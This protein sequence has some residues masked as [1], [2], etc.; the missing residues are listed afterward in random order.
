MNALAATNLSGHNLQSPLHVLVLD[1]D[2]FDR[3]RVR[4]WIE[5]NS[6]ADVD[7]TEAADLSVFERCLSQGYFDLVLLDYGL[8]DGTGLDAVSLL[9]GHHAQAASY[10]VMISGREDDS[11]RNLCLREGCDQFMSKSALDAARIGQIIAAVQSRRLPA[12]LPP[13]TPQQSAL[14]YWRVRAER[15]AQTP[16]PF[17]PSGNLE[18]LRNLLGVDLEPVDRPW[19]IVP[20]ALNTFALDDTLS[21][22]LRLFIVDFLSCDEFDF[23]PRTIAPQDQELDLPR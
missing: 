19:N 14:D 5:R 15:R 21:A 8:A 4:R 12:A 13:R 3:K 23:V 18:V 20:E 9:R 1:D 7:L 6:S 17:A 10:V 2:A 11:L 16:L 22:A